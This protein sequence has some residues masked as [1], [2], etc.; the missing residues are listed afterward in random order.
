[1]S[2]VKNTPHYLKHS[3]S[4]FTTI[5][6]ATIEAIIDPAALGIYLYLASKPN[7]WEISVTNLRNRFQKGEDFIR[8]RLDDL[9][10]IGLLKSV[11]IKNEKGQVIRWETILYNE[12]QPVEEKSTTGKNQN[13]ENPPSGKS[14][15]VEKPHTTNKRIKKIKDINNHT[16][17]VEVEL[18][19]EAEQQRKALMLREKTVRHE[20]CHE[21]YEQLPEEVKKDKTFQD[22]HDECVTH[23][24]AQI[25]PQMVSP[26]RLMSWIKREIKF[27]LQPETQRKVNL[28]KDKS[29]DAYSRA[30]ETIRNKI[31]NGARTYDQHGNLSS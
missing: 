31:N 19:L 6:N 7:D 22:I 5:L 24:A 12:I 3:Q 26:Q 10:R 9:K 27:N 2:I 21:L 1:M 4:T 14:T 29:G 30:M 13:L 25:E 8:S 23:Y 15:M 17:S 11:A 18:F 16:H 28:H 20:K